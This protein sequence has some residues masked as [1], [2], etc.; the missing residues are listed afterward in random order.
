MVTNACIWLDAIFSESGKVFIDN[1]STEWIAIINSSSSSNR[2]TEAIKMTDSFLSPAMI[3]FS[4]I[5]IDLLFT[6]T[7]GLS[8]GKHQQ[9]D[10]KKKIK[11]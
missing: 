7:Y 4:L 6:Q 5:S 11:N 8:P 3:E 10:E 2:A 1:N 9:S